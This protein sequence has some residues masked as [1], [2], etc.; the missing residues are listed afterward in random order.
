MDTNSRG[1]G[2]AGEHTHDVSYPPAPGLAA[3]K[4][5]LH[6]PEL[7]TAR[8]QQARADYRELMETL[9]IE[10]LKCTDASGVNLAMTRIYGR[11]SRGERV[12]GAVPQNY[13]T[14]VTMIAALS[15]RG[16]AAGGLV[17]K[18]VKG[19]RRRPPGG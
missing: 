18:C 2:R 9:D 13:G 10:H 7:D 11:A 1:D 16:V 19:V 3:P 15:S 4:Q 5:S 17:N 12:V 14:Y 6:A 8:V